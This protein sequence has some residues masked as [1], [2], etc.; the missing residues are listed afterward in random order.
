MKTK[1]LHGTGALTDLETTAAEVPE[2]TPQWG[3]PRPVCSI[4]FRT[5]AWLFIFFLFAGLRG[6]GGSDDLV[7][8]NWGT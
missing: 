4:F 3:G 7:R 2:A 1:L 8:C 6:L 5:G